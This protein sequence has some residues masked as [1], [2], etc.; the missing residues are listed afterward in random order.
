MSSQTSRAVEQLVDERF[1]AAFAWGRPDEA[2]P[3]DQAAMNA[4]AAQLA[5]ELAQ[6]DHYRNQYTADGLTDRR[7]NCSQREG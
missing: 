7:N 2:K 3:V 4:A 1:G 5:A 6:F